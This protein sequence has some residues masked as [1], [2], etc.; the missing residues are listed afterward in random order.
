MFYKPAF[1]DKKG[2]SVCSVFLFPLSL[3]V[4]LI[5]FLTN[6]LPK[7]KFKI[8]SICVG[9]IYVGGTGKTPLVI[10]LYRILKKKNLHLATAKKKYKYQLDEEILLKNHTN[11]ITEKN[12][13]KIF[14]TAIKKKIDL[15]I[16][17]DGLQDITVDYDLKFICM[18]SGNLFG[19]RLLIPAGPLREKISNLKN[20]DAI[21]L[22]GF[23][24][25]K[26]NLN[27]IKKINP[28]ILIFETNYEIQNLQSLDKHRK[29]YI[30]SGIGDPKSFENILKKYKISIIGHKIF[31]DHYKYKKKD[32]LEILKIAKKNNA[33]VL[34]TE[35]D[36]VKISKL[37]KNKICFTKIIP[38]IKKQK[39][40]EEFLRNKLNEKI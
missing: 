1:W 2:L 26:K 35:K 39:K 7:K 10:E 36:Y 14:N 9:N 23:K 16:F 40:L 37:Y 34:T 25:N 15:L 22:N 4:I 17:D 13:K 21:F 11:L 38:R 8:K 24:N 19:N 32:I 18:K 5:N 20:Y 31:P 28:K 29:Y 27:L 33:K 6:L 12:R 3:M 30:F